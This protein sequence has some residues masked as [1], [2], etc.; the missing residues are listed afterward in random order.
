M[1]GL[2]HNPDSE[3]DNCHERGIG[4]NQSAT[5]PNKAKSPEHG[6]IVKLKTPIFHH[7]AAGQLRPDL[8]TSSLSQ[9][10]N[11]IM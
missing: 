4:R 9:L 1:V 2:V 5:L 8:S 10:A 3:E 11:S 6:S 7:P